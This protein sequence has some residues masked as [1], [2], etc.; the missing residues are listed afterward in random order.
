MIA[1]NSIATHSA[2][3]DVHKQD[4]HMSKVGLKLPKVA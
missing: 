3:A 2:V 4:T 1:S